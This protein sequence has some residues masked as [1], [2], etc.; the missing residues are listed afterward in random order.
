VN[1]DDLTPAE[2]RRL[3]QLLEEHVQYSTD[4]RSEPDP[5]EDDE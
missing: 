3:I 1:P 2:Q 5:E 4:D